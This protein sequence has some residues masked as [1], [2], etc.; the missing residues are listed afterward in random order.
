MSRI[1]ARPLNPTTNK[2]SI[3][4]TGHNFDLAHLANPVDVVQFIHAETGRTDLQFGQFSWLSYF[5]PVSPL[6]PII[7][8]LTNSYWIDQI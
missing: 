7:P 4:I 1:L 6:L 8:Y 5:R 3:A 2:F